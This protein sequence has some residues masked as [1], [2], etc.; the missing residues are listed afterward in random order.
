ML[1][2]LQLPVRL[3]EQPRPAVFLF[4]FDGPVMLLRPSHH[5]KQPFPVQLKQAR[6][7]L[8]VV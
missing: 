5:I 8:H 4:Q 1:Y 2:L 6:Q 7:L 3:M